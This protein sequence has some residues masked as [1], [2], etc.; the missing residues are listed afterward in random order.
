LFLQRRDNRLPDLRH[1]GEM[2][3][4]HVGH[5]VLHRLSHQD[6]RA[7][8]GQT[9]VGHEPAVHLARRVLKR[10]QEGPLAAEHHQVGLVLEPRPRD[11]G[12]LD[13]R[14]REL[15]VHRRLEPGAADFAF[16]LQSVAVADKEQRSRFVDR[17][18]DLH[19]LIESC[20]ICR[21]REGAGSG[22]QNGGSVN[23]DP[24]NPDYRLAGGL[25]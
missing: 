9:V 5:F 25:A 17:Q 15:D 3:I 6:L 8:F 12:L 20:V 7:A 19:A 10:L 16:A 24:A 18:H 1:H 14:H 4:D 13:E 2:R 22:S 23:L 11:R 21:K